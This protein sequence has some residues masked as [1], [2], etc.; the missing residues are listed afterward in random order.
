MNPIDQFIQ[1]NKQKLL[2]IAVVGD[3]VLDK[4][5]YG[6]VSRIS[7]EFPVQV[8]HSKSKTE[9]LYPGGAA[10]VCH[11]MSHFNVDSYLIG[12]TDKISNSLFKE[13]KFN[14]DY[15]IELYSG[16]IPNKIRFYDGDFPLLR[17]DIEQFEYGETDNTE[18]SSM[19]ENVL[20]NFKK[21]IEE[22][23][24]SVVLSDYNKGLWTDRIAQEIIGI[25]NSKGIVTIVDP[26]QKLERW[27]YCAIFKP[28]ANEAA[29]LTGLTDWRLQADYL[30]Q[31]LVCRGVVITQSGAGV[32]GKYDGEYFE[33]RTPRRLRSKEVNSVIGAGD[34]FNAILAICL[35][36]GMDIADA[37]MIA[38]EGGIQYVK[39]RHNKPLTVNDIH[40]RFDNSA[41]KIVSLEELLYLKKNIYNN[42][43]FVFTNG[44]FDA[45]LTMGHI[46][47]LKFAK[48][49]GNKLIVA[50]NSD[51]SVKRLKGEGRPI[52][53]LKDRLNIVASLEFVDFVVSFDEDTP[54]ELIKKIRP[55]KICKG[56]DYKPE[57]VVGFGWA[58]VKICPYYDGIS[59]TKKLK[60]ID[61]TLNKTCIRNSENG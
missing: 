35:G 14:S 33:Y 56:G 8:L 17:W 54:I 61:E 29:A 47:C 42:E 28:N 48:K 34:C 58:D 20:G 7:P 2:R 11:Q 23:L 43:D 45:G 21:L 60:L 24:N 18:L 26:K 39:A 4:Y 22:G 12:F 31:Q 44:V 15:C 1:Y 59:T 55:N 30:Q 46:E 9:E 10:N 49:Y 13:Y 41:S 5:F 25:C 52:L 50:I 32:A 6:H 37:C 38:F 19:R 53:P 3:V 40:S 27:K 51:E 36:H 57:E 16:Q